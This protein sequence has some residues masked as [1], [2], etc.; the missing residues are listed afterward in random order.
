MTHWPCSQIYKCFS[1]VQK[2]GGRACVSRASSQSSRVSE[3]HVQRAGQADDLSQRLHFAALFFASKCSF[4]AL[5]RNHRAKV[6][7]SPKAVQHMQSLQR[8]AK[9]RRSITRHST[10]R[11]AKPAWL[12]AS[13]P[14]S[15]TMKCEPKTA[16]PHRLVLYRARCEAY[17]NRTGHFIPDSSWFLG[18]FQRHHIFSACPPI[19]TKGGEQNKQNKGR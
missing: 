19:A 14:T 8:R 7:L 5:T 1:I 10:A 3:S 2:P 12:A 18:K 17:S 15:A 16:G 13:S 4:P 6:G 9:H 11:Q